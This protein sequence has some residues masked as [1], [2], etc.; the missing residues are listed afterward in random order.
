[1]A[2]SEA[3]NYYPRPSPFRGTCIE[4]RGGWPPVGAADSAAA[5]VCLCLLGAKRACFGPPGLRGP[6]MWVSPLPR[7][8]LRSRCGGIYRNPGKHCTASP[9]ILDRV[10][11]VLTRREASARWSSWPSLSGAELYAAGCPHCGLQHE[12]M[13]IRAFACAAAASG[14]RALGSWVRR[15]W[16]AAPLLAQGWGVPPRGRRSLNLRSA[17]ELLRGHGP[18][19]A[20]VRA[21]MG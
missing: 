4:G 20:R 15:L 3:G 21:Y 10:P 8:V 14:P 5:W 13:R 9:L 1:M 11:S 19:P 6:P 2:T 7:P 12:A 18:V 17:L 16:P